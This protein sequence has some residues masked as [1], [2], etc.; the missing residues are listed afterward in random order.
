MKFRISRTPVRLFL[1]LLLAALAVSTLPRVFA[2][3]GKAAPRDSKTLSRQFKLA[4]PGYDYSFPRDHFSHPEYQTEWWYYTGHLRSTS[5]G[6]SGKTFGYQLT[7]FRTSLSPEE[8]KRASKWA[9]REVVFAHLALTDESNRK[10]YFTDKISRAA[11]GLA[12]ARSTPAAGKPDIWLDDWQMKFETGNGDA[13]GNNQKLRAFGSA[14]DNT[15]FGLSLSQTA[16]KPLAIHGENGV[17][18]KSEGRGRASHYYSFTRLKSKGKVRIG[19]VEYSVSGES[20]FDH[21]FGSNQLAQN[22]SGWDWFSIQLDDGRELMLYQLRLKDGQ[23]DP[24]S[25]GTLVEKNGAT[26]HLKR[27]EFQIEVLD[28]W[29]SP[30]S[31]AKY[32]ARWNLKVPSENI[33][34][35]IAPTVAAQ[36]LDT[37][38][39]TRI[40]YWEGSV[41]A[42]GTQTGKGYVELTG[43]AQEFN[44]TF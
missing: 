24:Y 27:D 43:Y 41:R 16:Q 42:T 11:L 25:S 34:L 17:S 33:A 39:S 3:K 31:K 5:K 8:T 44:G 14:E 26:R 22:Q 40:T 19:G 1:C 12:G 15:S 29:N 6:N 37:K 4:L 36:E 7:F 2:V 38:R 13:Q 20:W 10:F 9:T 30:R 18:Q 32:P 21:E 35:Q 28:F 23:I